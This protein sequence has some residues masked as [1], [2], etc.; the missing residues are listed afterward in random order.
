MKNKVWENPIVITLNA[1]ETKEE[2]GKPC[3]FCGGDHPSTSC[4]N[5]VPN[6]NRS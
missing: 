1:K 6:P 2:K 4:P 3:F 5:P